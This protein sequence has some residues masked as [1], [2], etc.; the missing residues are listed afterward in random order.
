MHEKWIAMGITFPK[1]VQ[2]SS[3]LTVV[4]T[5]NLLYF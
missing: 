1:S 2:N 5:V 4:H 3:F